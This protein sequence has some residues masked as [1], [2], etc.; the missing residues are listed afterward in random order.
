M[1]WLSNKKIYSNGQEVRV[2]TCYI[3]LEQESSKLLHS[4]AKNKEWQA[5]DE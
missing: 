4:G 5:R 2:K 1:E 3:F